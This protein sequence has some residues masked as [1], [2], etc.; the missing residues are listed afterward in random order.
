MRVACVQSNV[1]FGD[2]LANAERAVREL[3]RLSG[4]HGVELAVFPEAF[5]TGYC[6]E[7][8]EAAC[9]IAIPR[10]AA[11]FD[12]LNQACEE[13][14]ILAVIGFAETDGEHLF[15]AAVLLEPGEAPRFY[16]KSHLPELGFDNYVCVGE[17]LEVFETKLGR[18]GILICF[19]LRIPEAT[20]TLAL[21]GAEIL[22]LPTN[23]PTGADISADFIAISRAAEN[24]I[25]IATC[26]R[27]GSENGFSFIGKSK[28]IDV[29]GAILASAGA[30]EETIIADVDLSKARNKRSV[31]IP[32]KF[33]T[34]VVATRQPGLYGVL[35]DDVT[36]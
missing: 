10:N 16:R 1:V 29:S 3:E 22:V 36:R 11:V 5:L 13:Y 7:D 14:G 24:R 25:F 8:R 15:N 27:V 2:P 19:D 9:A 30:D 20:R 17:E 12:E 31:T 21:K 35:V 32:G 18:I 34:N 33:E 23:W 28:I 26:D 4:D 6:V